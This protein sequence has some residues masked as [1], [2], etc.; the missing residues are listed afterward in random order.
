MAH[1]ALALA[2]TAGPYR[3]PSPGEHSDK[4][5]FAFLVAAWLAGVIRVV[6]GE[7]ASGRPP[8]GGPA[9]YVGEALHH[10]WI[11]ILLGWMI[12]VTGIVSAAT[13]AGEISG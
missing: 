9:E 1:A 8:A 2:S 4:T 6:L 7:L 3:H 12:V 13:I 11:A 5:P 10:S